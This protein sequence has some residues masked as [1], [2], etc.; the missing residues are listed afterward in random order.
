ALQVELTPVYR[1]GTLK[2]ADL[3]MQGE[4][5]VA[6]N[7]GGGFHHAHSNQASGFCI[8]NDVA[9][10]LAHITSR[11]DVQRV[12][13]LDIDAHHGDGV[14]YAFYESPSV[15][16]IDFHES[17]AY[18]FPGTGRVDEIGSGEGSGFKVNIPL[19]PLTSDEAFMKAFDML[20]PRLLR[21]YEPEVVLLQSGID[22]H[23]ADRVAHLALTK[24]SY[25]HVARSVKQLTEELCEGRVIVTG[26]G[27]YN[28]L[29]VA[30]CWALELAEFADARV[31]NLIP[32]EWSDLYLGLEGSTLTRLMWSDE[33]AE[34][35]LRNPAVVRE[36]EGIV[37]EVKRLVFPRLNIQG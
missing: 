37:E 6:F 34:S 10:C 35:Q 11:Y 32:Q 24:R 29:N 3:V 1:G 17:G 33:E 2:A 12:A 31:S 18:L 15:L 7:L 36:V 27:G 13:Y 30:R 9:V 16:D 19:P 4:V 22:A 28:T 14:M 21:A 8:F 26:G 23:Y 20:V 25:A 5:E